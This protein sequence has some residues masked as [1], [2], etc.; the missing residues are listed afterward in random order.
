MGELDIPK[1][2]GAIAQHYHDIVDIL[3]IAQDDTSEIPSVEKQGVQCVST[4]TLMKSD[5]DKIALAQFI[6]SLCLAHGDNAPPPAFL[7][8]A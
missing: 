8:R 5:D 4:Q 7:P 1:T 2:S 6:F 3:V